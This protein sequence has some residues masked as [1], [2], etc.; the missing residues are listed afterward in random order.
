MTRTDFVDLFE[1][2]ADAIRFEDEVLSAGDHYLPDFALS[3]RDGEEPTSE[4]WQFLAK[5]LDS[6]CC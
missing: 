5:E 4:Y 3:V 2:P 6:A 1:V